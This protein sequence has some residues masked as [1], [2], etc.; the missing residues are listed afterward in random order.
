MKHNTR[1]TSEHQ[2]DL[3]SSQS[4]EDWNTEPWSVGRIAWWRL[5][6]SSQNAKIFNLSDYIVRQTIILLIKN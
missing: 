3:V 4:S 5:A 6:V 2:G 1:T